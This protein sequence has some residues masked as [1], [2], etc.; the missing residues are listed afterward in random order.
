MMNLRKLALTAATSLLALSACS[1]G[2]F[3]Y[4]KALGDVSKLTGF[5][6]GYEELDPS[7]S[8]VAVTKA[9]AGPPLIVGFEAIRVAIPL[10]GASGE[11]QTYAAP[12]GVVIAMNRGFVTRATGLGV[13]LNGSYLPANSAWFGGMAQA[14]KNGETSDR[15]IEYWEQ[16]RL[17]RD[18][19][20]CS[21]TATPREGGG[22]LVDESCK[23]YFE[24]E[25]FVNRY[26]VK[27]DDT[28]ECSRQWIN[29]K[30]SPL[31]FFSTE[32]QALTLDL[33][34]NGC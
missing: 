3:L 23:R 9:P 29:P 27:A 17:K 6:T 34:K 31:Q 14:A 33:T 5:S 22:T 18:K 7:L 21:L 11:S 13:D 12:D 16:S 1:N 8:E 26:W 28:I 15:V 20:R 24:P 25:T 2:E 4:G 19:F 32:Q 10:A 30:L